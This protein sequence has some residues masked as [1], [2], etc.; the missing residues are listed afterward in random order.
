MHHPTTL[1]ETLDG[2]TR[3]ETALARELS[4]AWIQCVA[5]GHRCKIAPGHDGICKVRSNRAGKLVVPF[6]YVCGIQLDPVEKKPFYHAYP[7]SRALS[8]GMLGCDYHCGYCQNWVSSQTLRDPDA[9]GEEPILGGDKALCEE[10]VVLV[11]RVDVRHAPAIAQYTHRLAEA[12]SRQMPGYRGQR[13]AC[14]IGD[15]AEWLRRGAAAQDD[16]TGEQQA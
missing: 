11:L 2:M 14:V 5:C 6:G 4:N 12:R 13:L 8:Y 15:G 7:G 1:K 16:S 10:Q 3:E 9:T